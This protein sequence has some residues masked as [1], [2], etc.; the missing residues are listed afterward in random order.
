MQIERPNT[1]A[2]LIE[3]H[4]YIAGQI[5]ATRKTLNAL[6][7]DL[8]AVE[9]T[10]RLFD[11]GAQL[12]RA[13][14]LPAKEAAFKGEMRRHVLAALRAADQPLTSLEIARQVLEVR[15]ISEGAVTVT[16]FRKRVG[17]CLFK[18]KVAG[19]VVEVP[20]TGEYKGWQLAT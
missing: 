6:V 10:I 20:Q 13:K 12:G 15:K 1:V 5:E 4:R 8:E 9:H 16:M 11:P 2:G 18:L 3:K 19:L 7:F 14:P 17:A